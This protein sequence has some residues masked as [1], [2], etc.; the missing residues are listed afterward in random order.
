MKDYNIALDI[1]TNSVGW[2]VTD[3]ENNLLKYK[4]KNMWGSRIFETAQTAQQRRTYRGTKRRLN[5]RKERINMLQSLLQEDIEKEYPN[6]LKIL[7]E[8][9]LKFEDKIIAEKI[10]GKKYNIFSE[11]KITDKTYFKSY[12]TIYHLRNELIKNKQKQ[13]IRLIYLAIHHIIKYRGNFLYESEFSNTTTQINQDLK[14]IINFLNEK[15]LIELKENKEE[16]IKILKEKTTKSEKKEKLFKQFEYEKQDKSIIANIINAIVGNAFDI[17]KIFETELDKKSISFS[18]DIENEEEIK[19]TIGEDIQVYE[20]LKNIYSYYTLQDI[21]KGKEYISEA[22]IEKYEKYKKDLKLIKKIYKKYFKE[23]YNK[24]FKKYEKANYVAYNGKSQGKT[25]KKCSE[26]EFFTNLKKEIN[27]LPEGCEEKEYILKEIEDNNFL[28]KLNITDNSQIPNQIHKKELEQILENQSK[29]YTTIKE[30]KE[31]IISLLTYR[32]PYY[33]GPLSKNKGEWSWIVRKSNESIR[34]WKNLEEI[35]DEDATAEE[36]IKRMTNKCTYLI[37]KNVMPRQSL[38][39]SK[40]CVLNELNN[41]KIN[42]KHLG[43]DLKEKIIT[44]LFENRKKVTKKMLENFY[45]KEMPASEVNIVGLSNESNFTSNM[46]SYIDL[47]NIFGKIDETNYEMCEKLIYWITIFEEKKILKKK[48]KKEYPQITEEQ[49]N[50]ICKLKYSGWSRISRELLTQIKANDGDNII[51]KLEKTQLNFMQIINKKEFGIN[52]RIEELIPK[53]LDKITYKNIE[54]IPT[55]PANKRG[56][57]QTI[58]IVKEIKKIMKQEPKN[59][60]I[61]FARNEGKKGEEGRKDTRAKTILKKYE[62]IEKQIK[63]LK[64]YDINVYKELKKNQNEKN[65]TEKMYLYYLQNGKCLYSGERLELDNLSL[66]EV[67]HIIPR[68]YIKDDSIDNKALVKSRENQRKK[69]NLL[70]TEEIII[71]RQQWWKSLLESGLMSPKKY[72]NLIKRKMFETNN[73]INKFI[74][75]QLVETRQITK[76]VTNLLLAECKNT[77]IFSIRANLTHEFREKYQIYKNRNL[78]NY[79][80]AHDA[81]ILSIIGNSI[82]D[83]RYKDEYKYSEYVKKYLNESKNKTERDKTNIIMSIIEKN[84]KINE[85]KKVFEYKDCYISRK[86]EEGTGEFYKQTLYSP[87]DKTTHPVIPLKQN[88][89]VEKYGGYSGEQKAYSVIFSFKNKKQQLE[90]KLIGIPIQIEYNIKN[91][92]ETLENYIKNK[93]LKNIEFTDFKI[94]KNK[95]LKNQEY[96]D[97]NNEPM[98]L[99]SDTEYRVNKEL[100]VNSKM[101]QLIYLMNQSTKD[102]TDEQR[103]YITSNYEYMYE[104]LLEKMQKEYKAFKTIIEKLKKQQETYLEL[105]Y[106]DKKEAINGLISLM[107]TGQGNLKIIGLTEREGRK[108]GKTFK[109][110]TIL[111]MTFIDKSV[112]GMYER[113]SKINGLE[114]SYCK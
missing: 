49:I 33:I 59:I 109:N 13:D 79:H 104:Y 84:I 10:L 85:I 12:P 11:S 44:Q 72:F 9:D 53:N 73:D 80:H 112:T 7:K 16:I 20:S 86:L 102:T 106:E 103:E 54:E 30:N 101:Q 21:L 50:K 26:E 66:Y 70:L 111:K 83:S 75:R 17:N 48:I 55:S 65:L 23:R 77:E 96:L 105:N 22:F 108:S 57:W 27:K 36:F 91:K 92:K 60:Y 1:G 107:Q 56:I 29:Y 64:D 39:Y 19:E 47:T 42:D 32:I 76:Y 97:E 15:Y 4:G 8:T 95:I 58:S 74:Q 35:I 82:K 98:R 6:F 63:Y 37:N 28:R 24:M 89:N 46:S 45:K 52:K 25:Y 34:P 110:D 113:R 100:I 38:L 40:F 88:K 71:A 94:L 2:A 78:N 81:Y 51:E 87:K 90:Y 61:E 5:R 41:I 62:E 31:K 43:R 68:T 69:D 67:D 93:I 114:N 14:E 3:E 18:K 99:C